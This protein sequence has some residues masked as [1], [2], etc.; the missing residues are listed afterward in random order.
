MGQYA[1]A[2]LRDRQARLCLRWWC[3]ALRY[4]WSWKA[5][6]CWPQAWDLQALLDEYELCSLSLP[7]LC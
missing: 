3:M 6:S 2:A 1:G 5:E 7:H 4:Q